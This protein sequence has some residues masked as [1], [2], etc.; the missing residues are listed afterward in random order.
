MLREG[1]TILMECKESSQDPQSFQGFFM[2]HLIKGMGLRCAAGAVPPPIYL[3]SRGGL[4]PP[5]WHA[6]CGFLCVPEGESPEM[7]SLLP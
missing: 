3:T 7:T 4:G 5:Q 2:M 1:L 6:S